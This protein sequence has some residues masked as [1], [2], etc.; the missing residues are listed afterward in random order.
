MDQLSQSPSK[1]VSRQEIAGS[2]LLWN[3]AACL[4]LSAQGCRQCADACPADALH[5]RTGIPSVTPQCTEC[6]RCAAACPTDALTRKHF[7]APAAPVLRAGDSAYI[8]CSKVPRTRSPE[9]AIRV[10]CLGAISTGWLL[11]LQDQIGDTPVILL[12]RGWCASCPSGDAS[13]CSANAVVADAGRM[14]ADAGLPAQLQARIELHPLPLAQMPE[15]IPAAV[16]ETMIS[17]RGFFSRGFSEAAGLASGALSVNGST[18]HAPLPP[19][20]ALGRVIPAEQIRRMTALLNIRSRHPGTPATLPL[21]AVSIDSDQCENHGICSAVCPTGALAKYDDNGTAGIRFN[22]LLCVSCRQCERDCPQQA[23]RF[24]TLRGTTPQDIDRELTRHPVK[25]CVKCEDEFSGDP[26]ETCPV[27]RK[28]QALFVRRDV[29][30]EPSG[31]A[32]A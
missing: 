1:A 22:A 2:S 21:P 17:R 26:G 11:T 28:T 9:G 19:L 13:T 31:N 30:N 4:P 20:V 6:A 29:T 27:C 7:P 24:T 3:N 8:D 25:V 16:E 14:L 10:P 32:V 23:V 15:A 18:G 12:N 5:F